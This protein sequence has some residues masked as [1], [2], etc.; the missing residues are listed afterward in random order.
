VILYLDTSSLVKLYIEEAGSEQV[1]S[2]VEESGQVVT[3]RLT[4]VEVRSAFAR[5]GREVAAGQRAKLRRQAPAELAEEYGQLLS[6]F[7]RDWRRYVK[8]NV[9][10]SL[11]QLAGELTERHVLR[12]YDAVHLA[13]ALRLRDTVRQPMRVST[14]DARLAEAALAEGFELAHHPNL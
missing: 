1:E 2:E 14:W 6:D 3:S 13:S 7:E 10:Q 5:A 11:L 9:A 12:G 8:V 4:Y